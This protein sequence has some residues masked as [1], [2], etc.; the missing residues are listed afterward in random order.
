MTEIKVLENS[1]F[2]DKTIKEF[3]AETKADFDLI[4]LIHRGKKIF[5]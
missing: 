3:L 2:C 1:P 5:F 4:A